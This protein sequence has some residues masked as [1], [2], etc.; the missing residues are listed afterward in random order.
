MAEIRVYVKAGPQIVIERVPTGKVVL[1]IQ[2]AKKIMADLPKH[3]ADAERGGWEQMKQRRISELEEELAR[4]KGGSNDLGERGL[5]QTKE[6]S[7]KLGEN[8]EKS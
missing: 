1:E 8:K 4:L 7:K 3:I 2:E 6:G 5:V